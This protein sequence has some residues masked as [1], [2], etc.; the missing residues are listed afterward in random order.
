MNT[1]TTEQIWLNLKT[2]PIESLKKGRETIAMDKLVL[3]LAMTAILAAITPLILTTETFG[4]SDAPFANCI[5]FK[6]DGYNVILQMDED[7]NDEQFF[8]SSQ[9]LQITRI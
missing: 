6:D 2:N 1:K 5:L 8:T 3:Q 9:S 4:Q 7:C